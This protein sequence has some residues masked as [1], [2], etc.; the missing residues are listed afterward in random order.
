MHLPIFSVRVS[1]SSL[2]RRWSSWTAGPIGTWP[3]SQAEQWL[4]HG[5]EGALGLLTALL[6]ASI[7]LARTH[8]NTATSHVVAPT[9]VSTPDLAN[10]IVAAHLF[11]QA[12]AHTSA[13]ALTAQSISVNG[14][15]Y[16]TQADDSQA[17]LTVNGKTDLYKVGASLS[18]GEKLVAIDPGDIQL[19]VNGAS[20]SLAISKYGNADSEGPAAYAAL[21]HG[22]GLSAPETNPALTTLPGV[23]SLP[24]LHPFVGLPS[25]L[26]TSNFATAPRAPAIRIPA[27]ATP[28]EQLQLLR[29]QLIH[30]N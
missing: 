24:A 29:Q 4:R 21:L 15:V 22:T 17:V 6:L 12:V 3:G 16:S 1:H 13:P 30:H 20:R 9:T 5:V 25:P 28:L 26:P 7:W 27:T 19:A 23:T 10:T 11:G 18:D 14:I 8:L 2:S